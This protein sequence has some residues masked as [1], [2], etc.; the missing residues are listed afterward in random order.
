VGGAC[1]THGRGEKSVQ[2]F[3]G[4]GKKPFGRPRRRWEDGIIVDFR[5]TGW[6]VG[7][8]WNQLAQNR[9]RWRVLVNTVMNLWVVEP[10][11]YIVRLYNVQFCS[12]Y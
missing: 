6:G 3:G 4:K 8:E 12:F 11:S 9:D 5:E 10:H 7:V 2:G 1:G